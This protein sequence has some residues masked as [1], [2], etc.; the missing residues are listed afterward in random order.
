MSAWKTIIELTA[1]WYV[2]AMMSLYAVGKLSGGQF[3]RKGHLSDDLKAKTIEQLSAFELAW[4]FFGYSKM[5]ILFIGLAQLIGAFLLLWDRTKL[6]GAAV[7]LG[8]LANIIVVDKE[9]GVGD[10]IM[11]AIFYFS[12]LLIILLLNWKRVQVIWTELIRKQV[13]ASISTKAKWLQF[14]AVFGMLVLAFIL[15]TLFLK[16]VGFNRF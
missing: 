2:F 9:F 16:L 12:L 10:A 3:Y 8:I 5:Y 14:A 15:E 11:S 4:T 13:T 1:R 6:L 7:L